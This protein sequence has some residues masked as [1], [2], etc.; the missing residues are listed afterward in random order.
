LVPGVLSLSFRENIAATTQT[1][2]GISMVAHSIYAC[3][4]GGT[5][6]DVATA[7]LET[8]SGGCAWNGGTSVDVVEP[9]SGQTYTVLFARPTPIPFKVRTTVSVSSSLINAS[10]AVPAAILAYA[11]GEIEGEAGLIVGQDVS[12]FE[13]A[14]A[15]TTLNPGIYVKSMETSIDSGSTWVTT[16]IAVGIDEIA[17]TTSSDISVTVE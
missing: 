3:V 10:T 5:D 14:G 11:N 13:L 6:N 4:D 16:P 17:T 8:K 7:L 15:V 12:A 1:I 2:D 9:A